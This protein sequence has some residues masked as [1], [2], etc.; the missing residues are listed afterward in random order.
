MTSSISKKLLNATSDLLQLS[1]NSE[2]STVDER[3]VISPLRAENGLREALEELNLPYILNEGDGAF[4]GPKID[5]KILDAIGDLRL[6]GRIKGHVIA[7]KSGH[8][9]NT[10]L[11]KKIL[12][13]FT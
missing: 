11:A 13:D 4:Y 1:I 3:E 9:L 6:A 8:E 12:A 2:P 7:V 10:K 5:I